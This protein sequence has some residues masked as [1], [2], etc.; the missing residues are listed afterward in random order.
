MELSMPQYV[1]IHENAAE[2][3]PALL[4]VPRAEAA[5][6]IDAL[7]G[8]VIGGYVLREAERNGR[9]EGR[10]AGAY[11]ACNR[12]GQWR[13][14]GNRGGFNIRLVERAG[15]LLDTELSEA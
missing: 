14:Q 2:D 9:R 4:A 7:A 10:R 8:R 11:V 13:Q 15:E 3:A 6:T 5:L 1:T 12:E